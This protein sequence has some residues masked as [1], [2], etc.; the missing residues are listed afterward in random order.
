VILKAFPNVAKEENTKESF[1]QYLEIQISPE[2]GMSFSGS[3]DIG[4]ICFLYSI[5]KTGEQ[6]SK[7]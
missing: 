1:Q 3:T 4:A 5:G 7:V 2:W 6:E